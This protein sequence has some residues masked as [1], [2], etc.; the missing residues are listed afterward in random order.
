M[1][2]ECI[3]H[4][5]HQQES[6]AQKEFVRKRFHWQYIFRSKLDESHCFCHRI[7]HDG[8]EFKQRLA[9]YWCQA[10]FEVSSA[11]LLVLLL[12]V[13]SLSI[14]FYHYQLYFR[15]WLVWNT[16]VCQDED[17]FERTRKTNRDPSKQRC[18]HESVLLL[19][20]ESAWIQRVFLHSQKLATNNVFYTL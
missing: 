18:S 8:R 10:Y 7:L 2:E 9:R 19:I 6:I 16:M 5:I 11:P 3:P 1:I 17:T 14:A 12:L 13:S 20:V 4:R 15:Y